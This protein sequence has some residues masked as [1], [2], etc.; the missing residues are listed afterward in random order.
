MIESS[1]F[2][3]AYTVEICGV[4]QRKRAPSAAKENQE[5]RAAMFRSPGADETFENHLKLKLSSSCSY[6]P[7]AARAA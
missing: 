7:R 6:N 4:E 3:L 2:H 1:M 5:E